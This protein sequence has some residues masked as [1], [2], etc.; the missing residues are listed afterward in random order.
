[1][2]RVWFSV[3]R[4]KVCYS[5][6]NYDHRLSEPNRPCVCITC[7]MPFHYQFSRHTAA[8]WGML[9][10]YTVTRCKH[11]YGSVYLY[12]FA[13]LRMDQ[14]LSLLTAKRK[15]TLQ[16]CLDLTWSCKQYHATVLNRPRVSII[17]IFS[18]ADSTNLTSRQ[19][20]E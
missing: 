16:I 12:S 1:M 4:H 15:S 7:P 11:G 10:Y 17:S 20:N 2:A 19:G 9:T 3:R 8:T 5:F 18:H 13:A 6:T 14:R